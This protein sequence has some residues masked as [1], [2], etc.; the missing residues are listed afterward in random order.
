MVLLAHIAH[1]SRLRLSWLG[2]RHW[3]I[4]AALCT[5]MMMTMSVGTGCYEFEEYGFPE[6]S[7]SM[8]VLESASWA[9]AA[10][11]LEGTNYPPM[12]NGPHA[13]DPRWVTILRHKAQTIAAVLEQPI[14]TV[15]HR[16]GA[17]LGPTLRGCPYLSYGRHSYP[18]GAGHHHVCCPRRA[19]CSS[20]TSPPPCYRCDLT[21][22]LCSHCY[23]S[24]TPPPDDAL[25]EGAALC[26][27]C[28]SDARLPVLLNARV[29][30]G[31]GNR[32]CLLYTSPSPR[33]RTRSRM[34]SSA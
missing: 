4:R 30:S 7:L 17:S 12:M 27:A 29:I 25:P 15:G 18:N 6:S 28:V 2:T 16:C 8:Q 14:G 1:S 22:Q 10:Y 19:L 9:L 23:W 13:C 34:P 20:T 3:I 21:A 32:V 24:V 11:R 5:A 31:G 26:G 33:D